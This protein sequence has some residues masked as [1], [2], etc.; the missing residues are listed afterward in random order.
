MVDEVR[1]DKV[2][3]VASPIVWE[4]D[5]YCLGAW[6]G[7]VRRDGVVDAVDDIGMW[8]EEGVGF[9]FFEGEGNRFLAKGTANFL[10]RIECMVGCILYE[11]DVGKATLEKAVSAWI[12]CWRLRK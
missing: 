6:I 9:D 5:V 10:E 4:E 8:R 3:E 2:L 7:F 1:I 11:V 12:E